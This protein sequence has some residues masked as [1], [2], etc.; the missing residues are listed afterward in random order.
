MIL[1]TVDP[2]A[3]GFAP[4]RLARIDEHFRRYVDDGRLP[5]WQILISRDR[6]IVHSS[7]YGH[8]DCDAGIEW[9]DDTVVRLYSMTK[10]ITSVAAMVLDE[11]GAFELKDPLSEFIPSFAAA[12]V[13]RSGDHLKPVTPRA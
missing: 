12:P 3:V 10:P 13:H 2:E 5:G 4:G 7:T 1:Q 8:R 11:Q 9:G 6:Q